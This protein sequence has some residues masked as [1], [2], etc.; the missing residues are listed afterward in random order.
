MLFRRGC[1]SV[2]SV[3]EVVL[4][5]NLFLHSNAGEG[6]VMLQWQSD[7]KVRVRCQVDDVEDLGSQVSERKMS[8]WFLFRNFEFTSLT[9]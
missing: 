5:T 1:A 7:N 6:M 2:F 9:S 3:I 8:F 4:V